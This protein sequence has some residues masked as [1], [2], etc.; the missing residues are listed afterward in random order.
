MKLDK[1]DR[2]LIDELKKGV[3]ITSQPFKYISKKIGISE[4][5]I[6]DKI[7][8]YKKLG[9]IRRFGAAIRHNL[10]GYIVNVMVVWNV[11]ENKINKFTGLATSF[12]EISHCY[13]RKTYKDWKY[14]VYTM[15]HTK[16]KEN[17]EKIIKEISEKTEIKDYCALYTDKEYKKSV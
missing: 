12:N 14:N 13:E 11:P 16:D 8:Q 15:I 9:I 4:E 10:V 5:K 2:K 7:S 17:A 6:F 1:I 3:K